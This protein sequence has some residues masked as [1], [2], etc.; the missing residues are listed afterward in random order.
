MP[1][2]ELVDWAPAAPEV[3]RLGELRR[4][5]EE[6][7]IDARLA[8]GADADCV[9]DL[10]VL[11]AAEPL[12]ERRWA[13]LMLALCRSGRQ[14]DALRAFQ[15]V[16]TTLVEELGVEPGPSCRAEQAVISQAPRLDAS[17][18]ATSSAPQALPSG[19]IS[20]LL[21][22]VEG[23]TRLW[24]E[25]P[26][27]MATALHRHEELI[28][29]AVESRSGALLKKRGEGDSTFSVFARASDAVAAALSARDALERVAC[30][31]ASNFNSVR[32]AHGRSD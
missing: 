4:S 17:T 21:T 26:K 18:T 23:S 12:R 30:P 6:E 13:Q 14:G 32:G 15:R 7:V 8:L 3:A 2:A 24:D 16:R 28:A 20:F 1:Y 10:E 11:V 29:V 5:V 31:T 27:A 19:V 9:A 25:H 22:D